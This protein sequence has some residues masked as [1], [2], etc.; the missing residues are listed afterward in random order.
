MKDTDRRSSTGSGCGP[1][2][3][4]SRWDADGIA[5]TRSISPCHVMAV[6]PSMLR[7]VHDGADL[8]WFSGMVRSKP[9]WKSVRKGLS[10]PGGWAR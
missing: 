7:T 6:A 1:E 4:V 2:F 10:V 5:V 3:R 9:Q 8:V